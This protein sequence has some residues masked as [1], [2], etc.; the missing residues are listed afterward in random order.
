MATDLNKELNLDEFNKSIEKAIENVTKFENIVEDFDK[1]SKTRS[2]D[3]IKIQKTQSSLEKKSAS[4]KQKQLKAR[5][6]SAEALDKQRSKAYVK[7]FKD[8]QKLVVSQKDLTKALNKHVKSVDDANESNKVLRKAIRGIDQ[9]AEGS[10][11]TIEKYNAKIVENTKLIDASADP[12]V[13][14]KRNIGNYQS[15]LDNVHPSIQRVSNGFVGLGKSAKLLGKSLKALALNPIGAVIVAVGVAVGLLVKALKNFQPVMDAVNRVLTIAGAIL[16]VLARKYLAFVILGFVKFGQIAI[17]V[18]T[19]ITKALRNTLNFLG[20]DTEK[21][22]KAI[23]SLD[24]TSKKLNETEDKLNDSLDET[25]DAL[26]NAVTSAKKLDDAEK[27]LKKSTIE[28]TTANAKLNQESSKFQNISRDTTKSLAE[29]IEA[30]KEAN[31]INEQV[32]A[33][34]LRL[35]NETLKVAELNASTK[36]S[37]NNTEAQ[38]L[39]DARASQINAE[40][41]YYNVVQE[42][43]RETNDLRQDEAEQQLDIAL[44]AYDKLRNADL[45]YVEDSSNSIGSRI[46]KLAELEQSTKDAYTNQIDIIEE[47][48][49][50]VIDQNKLLELSNEEQ[51]REYINGLSLSEKAANRL[52]EVYRDQIDA[53]NDLFDSSKE[54]TRLL[55]DDY[56]KYVSDI[57]SKSKLL[58]ANQKNNLDK[59]YLDGSISTERYQKG[60]EEIEANGV[61]NRQ[62]ITNQQQLALALQY[63][64]DIA[65]NK[66]NL[67]Q[68]LIGEETFL[69]REQELNDEFSDTNREIELERLETQNEEDADLAQEKL[70]K[71]NDLELEQ[72]KREIAFEEFKQGR[73]NEID[74]KYARLGVKLLQAEF[75]VNKQEALET[76]KINSKLAISEA[77]ASRPFPFNIPAI[78]FATTSSAK[79]ISGIAGIT[80]GF[81]EGTDNAPRGKAWGGEKGRELVGKDGKW[82]LTPSIATLLN[83]SGGEVVIPH[84][85]TE[86]ILSGNNNTKTIITGTTF[87]NGDIV[88]VVTRGNDRKTYLNRL[89]NGR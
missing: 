1:G 17:S 73:I 8:E 54:L 19:G 80:L 49:G 70:E 7:Q 89:S 63:D 22:D 26:E 30:Q 51:V 64:K 11:E 18:V 62:A 15:A 56:D 79:T 65:T 21:L 78:A 81:A 48:S 45:K 67:D 47:Y 35:A 83:F 33:N 87:R 72:A 86:A 31:R 55:G 27:Q 9:E 58:S 25:G 75:D 44:D 34:E 36:I 59:Q 66:D 14:Q 38:A 60:L 6:S 76:A 41:A 42:G 71:E 13:A 57:D 85:E 61:K 69:A 84:K 37:L 82:S 2:E 39:S 29:R 43:I 52:L 12:Y 3:R 74:N 24:E 20:K 68:K 28:L 5:Q 88:D 4:D 10:T 50:V 23:Q 40:T 32:S 16:D 46:S 53:Q 77:I